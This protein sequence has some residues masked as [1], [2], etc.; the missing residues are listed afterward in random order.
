MELPKQDFIKAKIQ[1]L[2]DLQTVW[3]GKMN[4]KSGDGWESVSLPPGNWQ[5]M[6]ML[7]EVTDGDLRDIVPTELIGAIGGIGGE[8]MYPNYLKSNL[9]GF[10]TALESLESS[11][12]AEGYGLDSEP[13]P[14]YSDCEQYENPMRTYEG[15]LREWNRR[16]SRVLDRSRCL[17][18]GRVE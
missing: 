9:D 1:T 8:Y 16:Q 17:L 4:F 13:E 18:L 11:I 3:S 7:S 5:V 2:V 10:D 14:S 15:R 6:G 12:L